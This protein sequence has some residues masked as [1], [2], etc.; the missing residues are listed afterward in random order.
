M[1]KQLTYLILVCSLLVAL[2]GCAT[3]PEPAEVSAPAVDRS[4]RRG[5]SP[6]RYC[7]PLYR[8]QRHRGN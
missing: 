3:P 6:D 1:P 7:P 4:S 8:G 2:T 5:T